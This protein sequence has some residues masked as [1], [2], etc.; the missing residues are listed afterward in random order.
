MISSPRLRGK[1]LADL[2]HR[3]AI[4][5]ESGIDVRRTWQRETENARGVTQST[6][7]LVREGVAAGAALTDSLRATGVFFPRLFLEMVEVGEKTGS[8]SVVLHRLSS[9]YQ[10]SYEMTRDFRRRL[11][12]PALELFAAV[13]IVGIMLMIFAALDVEDLNGNPVDLLG[14]GATGMDAVARYVQLIVVAVL[15]VSFVLFAFRREMAWTRQVVVYLLK[16]PVIGG[17]LEKI[18]L[19]RL[20]WAMHLTLNVEMDLRQLVPLALRSTDND[21]YQRQSDKVVQQIEQ[22]RTLHQ[23]FA[24]AGVFPVHFLDA[25]Q[26]AEE[27]GQLVES[28]GRMSKQYDEEASSAMQMLSTF[29]SFAIW[30][31]VM[32]LV[33]VMIFRLFGFYIQT[34]ND[35]TNL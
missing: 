18:C 34:I 24:S 35:A 11:V 19:A 29:L 4:S 26:V 1:R 22:G 28:T 5:D 23:S 12:W 10:R 14:I 32:L 20:A 16:L 8:L 25:L 7:A 15:A 21:F 33:V 31:G 3:L 9:H 2:C 27:S 6:Y 30:G 17:C 13:G